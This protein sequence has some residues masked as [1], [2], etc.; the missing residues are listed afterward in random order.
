M[1]LSCLLVVASSLSAALVVNKRTARDG[2]GGWKGPK[3]VATR[4]GEFDANKCHLVRRLHWDLLASPASNEGL[5]QGSRFDVNR[6]II[7]CRIESL[8][9]QDR[10]TVTD[11]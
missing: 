2:G 1:G 8:S 11:R 3:F 5:H 10:Q 6:F 7:N 4:D 9:P